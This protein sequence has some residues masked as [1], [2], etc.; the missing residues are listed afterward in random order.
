[1]I[2]KVNDLRVLRMNGEQVIKDYG[3]QDG[4]RD[5]RDVVI[6]Y[7]S[8]FLR[9]GERLHVIPV[10]RTQ[11]LLSDLTDSERQEVQRERHLDALNTMVGTK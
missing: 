11:V 8:Q 1:M 4:I 10:E 7:Y 5:G 3:I 2:K 6:K 9:T